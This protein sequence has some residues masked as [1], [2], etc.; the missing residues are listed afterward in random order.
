[1]HQ[2]KRERIRKN[3]CSNEMKREFLDRT[4]DYTLDATPGATLV[5]DANWR[6]D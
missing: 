5:L 1:L 4:A 3:L 6:P 2:P